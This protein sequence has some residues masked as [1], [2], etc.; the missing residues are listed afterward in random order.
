MW[1]VWWILCHP[2]KKEGQGK[3]TKSIYT[4]QSQRPPTRDP[5]HHHPNTNTEPQQ[6]HFTLSLKLS[7]VPAAVGTLFQMKPS[8]SLLD[9]HSTR[10]EHPQDRAKA[11]PCSPYCD[12]PVSSFILL[13]VNVYM[14]SRALPDRIDVTSSSANNSG[15]HS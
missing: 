15:N 4:H 1:P 10:R 8:I 14:C 6:A 13:F 2:Y 12:Y 7:F 5:A 9:K 3:C 11:G